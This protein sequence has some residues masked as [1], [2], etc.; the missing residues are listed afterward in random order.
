MPVKLSYKQ[1]SDSGRPLLVLHG[2][3]GSQS[4]WGWH[5]KKL[6]E[7]FAVYGVDMRNHGDSPHDSEMSYRAMAEDVALLLADLEIESCSL[8]GHSMGGKVAMQL[9]LSEPQLVEKLI[10]VDI[11]PTNYTAG[12]EGHLNILNGM[13]AMDLS[14]VA[15]RKEAEQ[16]LDEHIEDPDTLKFILTNLVREAAG[17]YRWRLN[18]D[19]LIEHYDALR[20]APAGGQ[21]FDKPVLF[22]KGELS[23]Y[24]RDRNE[25]EIRQLFPQAAI[26][27]VSGA[28]HWV[29]ADKP[30][31]VQ[32]LVVGFL[33][34]PVQS[35]AA[36]GRIATMTILS[37]NLNKIALATKLSRAGFS[38]C[39][40]LRPTLHQ[41]R[42]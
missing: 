34:G 7:H 4:N 31:E 10:V 6:A 42:C 16:L 8:L 2:L 23:G 14:A 25:A 30:Q 9:A 36:A 28:G 20:V 27:V 26:E 33:N 39:G 1:Y 19:A 24:I 12:G 35:H 17:T 29:H 5:C 11:A 40:Q 18:V 21:P 13:K 41:S 32:E 15:S 38:Q 22:I 3:F 37:V